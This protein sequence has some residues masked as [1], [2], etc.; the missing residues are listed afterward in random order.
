MSAKK[1]ALDPFRAIVSVLEAAGNSERLSAMANAAGLVFDRTLSEREAGAHATRIRALVPRILTAYDALDEDSKLL[2][3]RAAAARV[4][5]S[6]GVATALAKIGWEIRGDELVV[7]DAVVREM[8][9]PKGSQ[10]DAYVVLQKLVA[11]A[12]GELAVVDAYAD[13][14]VFRLLSTRPVDGLTVRILCSKQASAVAA[15]AKRF[16]A[17]H[18]GVTIE[19]RQSKDFHDRFLVLD[20][21]AC[22]HV[23]H[24]IKD[25]GN[26]AGMISRLED[27]GTRS[28]L[29]GALGKSWAEATPVS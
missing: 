21:A 22:I 27:E 15:E 2:A 5:D 24:S 6:Q 18:A 16:M 3:A 28:A 10:W 1:T 26:T 20:G 29:L 7:L 4:S 12:T 14:T 8:F 13:T 17:Q 11:E 9:F 19:V 25:A 23:G